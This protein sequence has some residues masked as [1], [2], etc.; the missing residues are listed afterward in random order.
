[1]FNRMEHYPLVSVVIPARNAYGTLR[2]A[3]G[4]VRGQNYP[5][6]E[7]IVVDDASSDA[8]AAIAASIAD[9][10][11]I[12]LDT[13]HGAARARNAGLAAARGSIVAFQD[14]DDEWLPG[15]LRRQVAQLRADPL[16]AFVAC[17]ARLFGAAGDDRG[18]L[19]DGHIPHTGGQ[20][21]RGLL[22]RNTIATPCVV[23]WRRELVACGGFDAALEVA[24]DQ[25][26]WIRLSLRG[27]LGYL[28]EPLVHVHVTPGSVSGVDTVLGARQQVQVTLPMIRRHVTQQQGRLS[29]QDVRRILGERL[30]RVGRAAYSYRQYADGLRMVL[31]AIGLGYRPGENLLFLLVASPPARWLKRWL[32]PAHA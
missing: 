1:M 7:I 31:E 30:C 27:H 14:A 8:T 20:T 23:A 16:L 19:Y 13:R 5:L 21:W 12:R 26:L 18:P 11:L 28:D 4:S 22:A 24:E 3:I 15:K 17:G 25:D 6:V 2:R 29:R 32:R 9:V 10:R